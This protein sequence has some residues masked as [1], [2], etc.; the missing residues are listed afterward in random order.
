MKEVYIPKKFGW[1]ARR[2]VSPDMKPF[3][4]AEAHFSYYELS[5][6]IYMGTDV[7]QMN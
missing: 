7:I 4:S 5:F 2:T 1:A 3:P 6:L